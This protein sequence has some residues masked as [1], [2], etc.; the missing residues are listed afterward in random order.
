MTKCRSRRVVLRVVCMGLMALGLQSV[1][2]AQH[3]NAQD[4]LS[5]RM[6]TF[7]NAEGETCFSLSLGSVDADIQ[8]PSDVIV[9][10]DTS[11][12]QTG[13]Y[14]QDS[15]TVLRDFLGGLN[16][17][18]RVKVFAVDLDP[19]ALN[20]EFSSPDSAVVLSS[21]DNLK[22]RV[23]LGSTDVIKMLKLSLIHI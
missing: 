12:S 6:A 20:Q 2:I 18:D 15:I 1:F 17:D 9:F 22:E 10:V 5:P 14:K 13:V 4:S 11:A 21:I 19:V 7:D 16:A 23:A 8:R 3:C